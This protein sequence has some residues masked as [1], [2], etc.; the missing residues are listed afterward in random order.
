MNVK[1]SITQPAP[2]I[3]NL[4]FADFKKD[5]F[6]TLIQQK[7]YN[8]WHESAIKCPCRGDS[9]S[10]H[11]PLS[12]CGNCGGSGWLFINRTKTKMVLHSMNNQTKNSEW[13][14]EKLGT[15]SITARD[16][17]EIGEMDRITVIEGESFYTENCLPNLVQGKIFSFL[18]YEPINIK[19]VFLFTKSTEPLT[20]LRDGFDFTIDKNKIILD[21]KFK[22]Y[23]TQDTEDD[24][25]RLKI[26]LRYTHRPVYH[27]LDIPRD[28]MLT[29]LDPILPQEVIKMPIHAIGRR[30]HYVPGVEDLRNGT[31][32]DNSTV[33]FDTDLE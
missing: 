4:P 19:F 7:G 2:S 8:V 18:A 24:L 16:V 28:V 32:F 6:E 13:S 17:D 14:L 9:E 3:E 27:V 23:L 22:K 31:L 30:A 21:N 20:I 12:D 26:S 33:V 5:E 25:N 10:G 29:N 11:Q 15:V 1:P